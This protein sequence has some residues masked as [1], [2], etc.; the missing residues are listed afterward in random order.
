MYRCRIVTLTG[1][2]SAALALGTGCSAAPPDTAAPATTA[3]PTTTTTAPTSTTPPPPTAA[4]GTD[5][6]ACSDGECEVLITGPAVVPVPEVG[7]L[8]GVE[9]VQDGPRL[10]VIVQGPGGSLTSFSGGGRG[11]F[12][13]GVML[14]SVENADGSLIL[15]LS[16]P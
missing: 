11:S 8:L 15:T 2:A 5:L 6:E 12:G 14:S 1:A 3:S 4:D 7:A 13:D 9:V 16:V 10:L